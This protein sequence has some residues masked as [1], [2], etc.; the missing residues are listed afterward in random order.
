MSNPEH[1]EKSRQAIMRMKELLEILRARFEEGEA[2]YD[3][4]FA[5]LSPEDMALKEKDRQTKAA[6]LLL[7]DPESFSR[8]VLHLRL[9]MRDLERD[10]EQ[11]YDNLPGD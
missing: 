11:L 7:K 4:L 1:V 3:A 9:T 10:F 2:A 6:Y 5:S 8:A